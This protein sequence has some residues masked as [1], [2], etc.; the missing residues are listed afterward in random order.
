MCRREASHRRIYTMRNLPTIGWFTF[1]SRRVD[2]L[3]GGHS[4]ILLLSV[5]S[6]TC[7]FVGDAIGNLHVLFYLF[8]C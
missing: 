1:F 6:K 5:Y 7:E 4:I 2:E 8:C 3:A